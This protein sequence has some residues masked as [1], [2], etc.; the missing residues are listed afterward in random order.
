MFQIGGDI[1]IGIV[2]ESLAPAGHG[3]IYGGGRSQMGGERPFA[4]GTPAIDVKRTLRIELWIS[5]SREKRTCN[6]A[7][8][9]AD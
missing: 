7:T 1:H 6:I 3:V 4:S 8:L 2:P 9:T 5:P